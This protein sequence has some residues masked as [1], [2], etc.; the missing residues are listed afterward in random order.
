MFPLRCPK[1]TSVALTGQLSRATRH[2][3]G[4]RVHKSCSKDTQ[5][6]SGTKFKQ[7][8]KS[9]IMTLAWGLRLF[10]VGQISTVPSHGI[11]LEEAE[12]SSQC[13]HALIM[14]SRC[15]LPAHLWS[16]PQWQ[17]KQLVWTV[18]LREL[19]PNRTEKRKRNPKHLLS[20]Q[21]LKGLMQ[22]SKNNKIKCVEF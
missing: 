8:S 4:S 11:S 10:L 7:L 6:A 2:T 3:W 16:I 5:P 12:W 13:S 15:L 1:Q 20:F 9:K 17:S 18:T 22:E 21:D 14:E 19:F